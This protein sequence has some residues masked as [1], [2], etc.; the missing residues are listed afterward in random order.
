MIKTLSYMLKEL[1]VATKMNKDRSSIDDDVMVN[2]L[3][4]AQD[5]ITEYLMA[6]DP[7][8]FSSSTDLTLTG[9]ER[10]WLPDQVPFDYDTILMVTQVNG[11]EEY[12]TTTTVWGDR[13]MYQGSVY[14][15][16]EPWSIRDQYIEF[17]NKPTSGTMRIWYSRRPKGFFYA[18]ASAGSTT[19]ATIPVTATKGNII[20]TDDYYIG[21]KVARSQEVRRI[22]DFDAYTTSSTHT[23]TFSPAMQTTVAAND[24]ISLV[25]P[26]PERYHQLIIDTAARRIR[27]GLD[28]D[29]SQFVR[30]NME[31]LNSA[32][33]GIHRRNAAPEYVR[34]IPR[35]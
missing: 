34:K 16:G 14:A 35:M 19:T 32:R 15:P 7:M 9:A 4:A 1:R 8:L 12:E 3:D 29:D 18:T 10:Y 25:S 30:M 11:T 23:I 26:L 20:S 2:A 24:V 5:E 13:I 33:G 21:M 6:Q 22:T 27:V 28:E 31:N 17:P